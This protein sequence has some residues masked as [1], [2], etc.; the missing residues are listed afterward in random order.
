MYG[1]FKNN[2]GTFSLH[3]ALKFLTLYFVSSMNV[4]IIIYCSLLRKTFNI[5]NKKLSIVESTFE[6]KIE[7]EHNMPKGF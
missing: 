6:E 3:V 2:I 1:F 4:V 7:K 5:K